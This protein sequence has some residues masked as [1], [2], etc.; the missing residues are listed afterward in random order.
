MS[1][2]RTVR[3][4]VWKALL[5]GDCKQIHKT[6]EQLWHGVRNGNAYYSPRNKHRWVAVVS[7]EEVKVVKGEKFDWSAGGGCG[8][9]HVHYTCPHCQN[10]EWCDDN[11][12]DSGPYLWFC[13]NAEGLILIE[14]AS[15]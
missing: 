10:H 7:E 14:V 6:E 1:E 5:D 15:P 9:I 3:M 8:G 13:Q 12:H 4:P 11:P 2:P